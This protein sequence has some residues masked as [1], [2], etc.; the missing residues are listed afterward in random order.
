MTM[1]SMPP[2]QTTITY[3]RHFLESALQ[4]LIDFSL[5]LSE[6]IKMVHDKMKSLKGREKALKKKLRIFNRVYSYQKSVAFQDSRKFWDTRKALLHKSVG[7]YCDRLVAEG[8]AEEGAIDREREMTQALSRHLSTTERELGAVKTAIEDLLVAQPEEAMISG[9]LA[10]RLFR[11]C[12][13]INHRFTVSVSVDC[14]QSTEGFLPII[15]A[16]HHP[17][18]IERARISADDADKSGAATRAAPEMNK[19]GV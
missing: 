6:K 10:K 12:L 18:M 11:S 17:E 4:C 13:F 1:P 16:L 5:P 9:K 8:T 15:A 19:L 2:P 3:P 14:A 7:N